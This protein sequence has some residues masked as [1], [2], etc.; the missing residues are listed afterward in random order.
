ML[1]ANGLYTRWEENGESISIVVSE[2]SKEEVEKLKT[3]SVRTNFKQLKFGNGWKQGMNWY[4][5]K[6]INAIWRLIK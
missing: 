3:E 4:I 2:P 1:G 6:S 5:V